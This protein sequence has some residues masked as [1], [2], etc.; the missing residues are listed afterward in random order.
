MQ[1]AVLPAIGIS[2]P[3]A[4]TIADNWRPTPTPSTAV[5]TSLVVVNPASVTPIVP[6]VV[7]VI[8]ASAIIPPR[9]VVIPSRHIVHIPSRCV[10]SIPP[11]RVVVVGGN[12]RVHV[13]SSDNWPTTSRRNTV[14]VPEAIG[15]I[16]HCAVRVL[17]WKRWPWRQ[18]SVPMPRRHP[19]ISTVRRPVAWVPTAVDAVPRVSVAAVV[20]CIGASAVKSTTANCPALGGG[21]QSSPPV[22]ELS[23]IKLVAF[24]KRRQLVCCGRQGRGSEVR[25]L[26]CVNRVDP[27]LPVELE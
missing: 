7:P 19:F 15:M 8:A 6:S 27:C 25:M 20:P 3:I 26:K 16:G 24:L 22:V 9:R 14:S 23:A 12:V 21:G 2:L 5:P 18:P 1:G 4:V 13:R 17:D 11:R 10:V